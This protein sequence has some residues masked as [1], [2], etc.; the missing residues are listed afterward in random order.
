MIIFAASSR[1]PSSDDVLLADRGVA[2]LF[3]P[4]GPSVLRHTGIDIAGTFLLASFCCTFPLEVLI[5]YGDEFV[6]SICGGVKPVVI[7][8]AVALLALALIRQL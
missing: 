1:I 4:I 6:D 7:V 2:L 8:L 3:N 5:V